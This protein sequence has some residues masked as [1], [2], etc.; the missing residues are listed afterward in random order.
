MV[1]LA[2]TPSASLDL[3]SGFDLRNVDNQAALN[4]SGSS[5]LNSIE[6]FDLTGSGDNSL[7]LELRRSA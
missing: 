5:R 2:L 6:A 7:T 4:T 1:A 3:A